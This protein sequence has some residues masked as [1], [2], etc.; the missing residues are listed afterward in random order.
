[1]WVEIEVRRLDGWAAPTRRIVSALT[2]KGVV[3]VDWRSQLGRR[4]TVQSVHVPYSVSTEEW[5]RAVLCPCWRKC[6]WE[7]G[8]WQADE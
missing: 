6:E 1:M 4:W 5:A 8:E 2:L 3:D 7:A